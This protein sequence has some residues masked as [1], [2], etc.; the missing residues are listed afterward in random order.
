M[1]TL[2]KIIVS[3]ILGLSLSSCQF[4]FGPG[5]SG[6][7][8]IETQER[9]LDGDFNAI[10]VNRGLD[11][12]ITQSDENSI[13]IQADEN[14]HELITTEIKNGVLVIST[15]ENIK[16]ASS[17]K[18]MVNFKNLSTIMA[19]SGSDLMSTHELS[20]QDLTIESSSGADVNLDLVADQL[21][22]NSSSGSDI[23]LRGESNSIKAISSSGSDINAKGLKS[24]IARAN[25]SSGSDIVVYATEKLNA[26]ANSGA[27]IIYYGNPEEVYKSDNASG[28]VV[29]R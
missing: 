22:C 25:A 20:F 6:N 9:T 13:T 15:T 19:N 29:K 24:K 8:I 18:V 7:G 2:V 10:D 4:S 26:D 3:T 16:K 23:K 1:N 28:S 27:D 12:Y 11:V 21:T 14:L 17:K 5:I